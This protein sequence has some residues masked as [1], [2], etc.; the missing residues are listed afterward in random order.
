LA[1]AV[2]EDYTTIIRSRWYSRT[3]KNEGPK[4]SPE[5]TN[6]VK[7]LLKDG[8]TLPVTIDLVAVSPSSLGIEN[9][10]WVSL[11]NIYSRAQHVC[12]LRL[13]PRQV[14]LE[15]C[16]GFEKSQYPTTLAVGMELVRSPH[17]RNEHLFFIDPFKKS[18]WPIRAQYA[19]L[20][21]P[22]DCSQVEFIFACPY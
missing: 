4:W 7:A 13:C 10:Q 11:G 14:V 20:V 6:V 12:G 8:V 3:K 2:V 18:G 22:R 15:L 5:K 9:P 1:P 17:Y 21:E 19:S 16:L